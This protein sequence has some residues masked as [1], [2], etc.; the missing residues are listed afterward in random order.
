VKHYLRLAVGLVAL[1]GSCSYDFRLTFEHEFT[2]DTTGLR[3]LEVKT[4]NGS[5]SVVG[6][7]VG[8][9]AN[10]DVTKVCYGRGDSGDAT[11]IS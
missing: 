11:H 9:V 10:F 3:L 5:F 1:L 7:Y 8:E 4:R 6:G 2:W